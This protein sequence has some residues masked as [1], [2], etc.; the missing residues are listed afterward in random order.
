MADEEEMMLDEVDER[1]LQERF[2]MGRNGDIFVCPF[3]CDYC[4]FRNVQGRSPGAGPKDDRFLK[5]IRRAI[6]D[7]LWAREASTVKSNLRE[8][9]FV[10]RGAKE[11]G[12][13]CDPLQVC[14]GPYPVRDDW[15]ML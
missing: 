15:G 8:L 1:E 3:Q 10:L 6:L 2:T 7:S 4:H 14:R 9:K 12:V 13:T 5:T 11:M